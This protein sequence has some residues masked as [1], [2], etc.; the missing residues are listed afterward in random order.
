M[1]D[2]SLTVLK[3]LEFWGELYD[4]EMNIPAS[5]KTF[6]LEPYINTKFI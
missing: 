4:Q 2:E 5:I 1:L 6:D 3:N